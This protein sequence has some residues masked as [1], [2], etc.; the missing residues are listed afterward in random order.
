MGFIGPYAYGRAGMYIEPDGGH[1]AR[2]S[3]A[4]GSGAREHSEWINEQQENGVSLGKPLADEWKCP[5]HNGRMCLRL[6]EAD[7]SGPA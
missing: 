5:Y 1:N 6:M 2:V 3:V 4:W 7:L